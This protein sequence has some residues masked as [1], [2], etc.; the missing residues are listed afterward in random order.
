MAEEQRSGNIIICVDSQCSKTT[1]YTT[2]IFFFLLI[3]YTKQKWGNLKPAASKKRA[4][5]DIK[6]TH[7]S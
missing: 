4:R 1:D 6:K 7:P 5:E 2:S 3:H